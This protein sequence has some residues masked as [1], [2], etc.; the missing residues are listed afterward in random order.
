MPP[1]KPDP[2]QFQMC[3]FRV[4][5]ERYAIDIR[6]VK[7][8][9][10]AQRV[11]PLPRAP[12]F[13]D[14]VIELRGALVPVVDVRRRLGVEPSVAAGKEKVLVC[15][16]GRGR[17]ALV[18]DAVTQVLRAAPEELKPAPPLPGGS[19]CV[20]G[21]VGAGAALTFLLDVHALMDAGAEAR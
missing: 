15:R 1:P 19:S 7:E 8:I 11:A 4:G 14:G 12:S 18:V 13:V 2:E 6:R 5:Q 9:L 21:A 17:I 20:L 3:A 10:G 16:V